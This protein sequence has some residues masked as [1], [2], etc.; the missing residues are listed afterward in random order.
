MIDNFITQSL[1][2]YK[3]FEWITKKDEKGKFLKPKGTLKIFF[4]NEE[5]MLNALK[6]KI[7]CIGCTKY[8]I[9]TW[10]SPYKVQCTRCYKFH[11]TNL[12][13]NKILCKFC[14]KDKNDQHICNN[15][16]PICTNCKG[17]HPADSK[18]CRKR[19]IFKNFYIKDI[20]KQILKESTE[21]VKQKTIKNIEN[22]IKRIKGFKILHK[23]LKQTRR[24]NES[25][26]NHNLAILKKL[27]RINPY[28]NKLKNKT[29]Y[30][31][32]LNIKNK[33]LNN[34]KH[35]TLNKKLLSKHSNNNFNKKFYRKNFFNKIKPENVENKNFT[36][37]TINLRSLTKRKDEL[38][39]YLIKNNVDIMAV[40]ETWINKK[41]IEV[42]IKN[43]KLIKTDP[44][45]TKG[46]GVAFIIKNNIKIRNITIK[47]LNRGI[48]YISVEISFK[49]FKNIKFIC[50][51]MHPYAKKEDIERMMP[52]INTKDTIL[53]GDF[54]AHS[55][56]WSQGKQ[57]QR[58]IQLEE[59]FK[60]NNFKILNLNLKPTYCPLN[61]KVRNSSP[62][63][64]TFKS[65]LKRF[66][67]SGRIG[68]D[69][70]SDHLPILFNLKKEKEKQPIN[71]HKHWILSS[72][73]ENEYIEN[74]KNEIIKL[75]INN[76]CSYKLFSKI[77]LNSAQQSCKRSSY[78]LNKGNPWWNEE[79]DRAIK[80]KQR[81]R[82]K[83]KYNKN[84][85]NILEY[86]K[87]SAEVRKII[88]KA[89]YD[90][91][92]N[93]YKNPSINDIYKMIRRCNNSRNESL[94]IKQNNI[95]YSN[96]KKSAN[97]ICNY[98]SKCGEKQ[99]Y[100]HIS[101]K[102]FIKDNL[103]YNIKINKVITFRELNNII[104][105]L[106]IKKAAGP[107]EIAPFMLKNLDNIVLRH[108]LK[109]FNNIFESG[110][111]PKEWNIGTII[112]IPKTQKN[113]LEPKEFRP[114]SLTS[115]I[116]KIFEN[117]M[118]TRLTN[119]CEEKQWLP[120]CQKGFRKTYSTVDNL[121]EL[122]QE[123]HKSFK[124]KNVFLAAFID[125][126]KAYD[127]VNRKM[128]YNKLIKLGIKGKMGNFLKH[129]LLEPRYAKVNYNGTNSKKYNFE[130]GVPQGSPLSPLLFN[131]YI[132]NII[133]FV[134]NNI[135]QFADDLVIWESE[136]T[137]IEASK[138]LNKKLINL[139]KWAKSL[140]LEFSPNKSF[141]I[142]FTM[143]RKFDY[144]PK[145]KLNNINIE[146]K[147]S[148]KYLG[149]ILDKRLTWKE[150]IKDIYNKCIKRIGLIN[151]IISN[152]KN[153]NTEYSIT[154]YK[155]M[156]RPLC[157]YASEIW[158]DASTSNKRKLDSIQHKY[159]TKALGV[160][161]LAHRTDVSLETK[162][163]PLEL[164][165]VE[166]TFK[167]Y[168]NIKMCKNET[169]EYI[170]SIC[171]Q[172]RLKN[173]RRKSFIEKISDYKIT[174]KIKEK[175]LMNYKKKLFSNKIINKWIQ[176]IK[177]KENSLNV[178]KSVKDLKYKSVSKNK[179][180]NKIWHQTRLEVL[181]LNKFLHKI[182]KSETDKC[183]YCKVEE[184]TNHFL[185]EC[186]KY[187]NIW[188]NNRTKRKR[189]N[190]SLGTFLN[191]DKPPPEIHKILK[192]INMS[193]KVRKPRYNK[194]NI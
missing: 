31:N 117:I 186:K 89:K 77:I 34:N 56:I 164:R 187:K 2:G 24:K 21:E 188:I 169:Y 97:I 43:Y 71:R 84:N 63:L 153:I 45:D 148:I 193:F 185:S 190:T 147:D 118:N 67:N 144:I 146:Y 99:K 102:K 115:V 143:R 110:E 175:D 28:N 50:I 128:L 17:A 47:N 106:N 55:P 140:E 101:I 170:N 44:N 72:L 88:K 151:Y 177:E 58:G 180:L 163:L 53:M 149:L 33:P 13:E 142:N 15:L 127:C 6:T 145:I 108:L 7:L 141:V 12:C 82:R 122:Q 73:N 139:N 66:I 129:F 135:S 85:I 9:R 68:K 79:C 156:I 59:F 125:I 4:E 10:G 124:R 49:N 113:I 114:I 27:K 171:E 152:I 62:D 192:C 5:A 42:K 134:D 3:K 25:I 160:N 1:R 182:K 173:N 183:P 191:P 75:N 123:I 65:S 189:I 103:E 54:N 154:L 168:I 30:N 178:P 150:H 98:F 26:L 157:E 22:E 70:G 60:E 94:I 69:I 130:K 136:Y 61:T 35:T 95:L 166:K 176:K 80:I 39:N 116:G 161:R 138:K 174:Y 46:S 194:R 112:P 162:V 83:L 91:W 19:K 8:K 172:Y 119:L 131:I 78:K 184:N 179:D 167:K 29:K 137:L 16:T 155:T 74:I 109:V 51:Y 41:T 132:N 81:L 52:K 87:I 32:I 76:R 36:I 120:K 86:K 159:L 100:R 38:T 121:I 93:M 11:H 40:Q 20:A 23:L 107:D 104:Q 105:K 90:Y 48:E 18:K 158:N 111:Y 37:S 92:N 181:P 96:N 165:R 14:G 64:V 126:R 57:N 133:K